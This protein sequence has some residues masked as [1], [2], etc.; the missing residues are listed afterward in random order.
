[1]NGG[2]VLLVGV[3][4]VLGCVAFFVGL[5]YLLFSTLTVVGRSM[6]ALF[7]PGSRFAGRPLGRSAACPNPKCRAVE[8][9]PARFCS[10]CGTKMHG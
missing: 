4:L 8:R 2:D 9:R 10:H 3:V 1:M 5:M 6:W 7:F